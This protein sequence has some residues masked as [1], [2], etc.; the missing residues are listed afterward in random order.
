MSA[1]TIK[2]YDITPAMLKYRAP[3]SASSDDSEFEDQNVIPFTRS[4]LD[5][6]RGG[7]KKTPR[8]SRDAVTASKKAHAK[9]KA[10][11]NKH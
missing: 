7:S 3:S 11:T 9:T 6:C 8:R 1:L 2:L 5:E 4:P 10:T